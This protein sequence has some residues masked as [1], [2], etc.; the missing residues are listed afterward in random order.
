MLH[1]IRVFA[2]SA[3]AGI[4]AAAQSSSTP[5][6]SAAPEG[7]VLPKISYTKANV[8]GPYIALT[9]DDGPSAANTPRLLDMLAKRNIKATFFVVGECARD[10]P[11]LLKRELAE[12]HE[13]ANHSWSHPNL[14]KM[15]DDAVRSQLQKTHDA[16][17]QATGVAPKYL[18]PPYGSFTERQRKWAYEQFGYK[19]IFWEVD[20][21][22]WK[23]PGSAVVAQRILSSTKPG[24]IILAHDIHKQTVDAMPEVLDGLLAKGFKFVTVSELIAMDH[25][26]PKV[27]APSGTK[28]IKD[29][30]DP[31]SLPDPAAAASDAPAVSPANPKK[32]AGS[33][34]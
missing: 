13:I 27:A 30:K 6:A 28:E 11:D 15:S 20:P 34:E 18:R 26:K 10:H 16:I 17:L 1:S 32:A 24:Y 9:F 33:Q 14:G 25:P 21:L 3:L 7:P 5:A 2:F 19:C 12:G 23:R 4:A 29:L 31:K 22:D 8:D